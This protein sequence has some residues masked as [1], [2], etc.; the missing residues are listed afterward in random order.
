MIC[1]KCN[2]E[3]DSASKFCPYCGTPN[4]PA[5]KAA[6]AYQPPQQ[7]AYVQ[8]VAAA[9]ENPYDIPSVLL[10]I[11]SFFDPFLGLILYLSWYR[12]YPRRAKSVGIAAL[13]SVIIK[14]VFFI[15]AVILAFTVFLGVFE[16]LFEEIFWYAEDIIE[17]IM[18]YFW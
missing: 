13:V 10:G 3:F 1:N 2:K 16:E 14:V 9:N 17:E 4:E 12:E 18:W 5:E 8:P 7:P 15:I 6:P 11:F